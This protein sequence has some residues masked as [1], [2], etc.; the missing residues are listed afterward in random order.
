MNGDPNCADDNA[1]RWIG[2]PRESIRG[3]DCADQGQMTNAPQ[4]ANCDMPGGDCAVD[5][6][7]CPAGRSSVLVYDQPNN[8]GDDP[9]QADQ[10]LTMKHSDYWVRLLVWARTRSQCDYTPGLGAGRGVFLAPSAR[11][12]GTHFVDGF[13]STSAQQ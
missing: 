9:S 13:F 7:R 6:N 2:R 1:G 3:A 12:S 10:D 11:S 5:G 4:G 8:K